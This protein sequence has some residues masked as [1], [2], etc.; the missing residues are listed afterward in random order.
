M[1]L[2]NM[3]PSER[4]KIES[5]A[6][7]FGWVNHPGS[8]FSFDCDRDGYV[9]VDSYHESALEN[10]WKAIFGLFHE[11]LVYN[12][13]QDYSHWYR[14]PA[15]GTCKCGREVYLEEDYGHGIDCENCGRIYSMSGSELA[16]RSQWEERY[17]ED[18]NL[19]YWAEFGYHDT[20]V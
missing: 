9:S 10:L 15:H 7:S 16:P 8:G 19:P 17:S 12:G 18:S 5:Y 4:I 2:T 20:E 6:H 3:V 1:A 14:E 11:P 13:I